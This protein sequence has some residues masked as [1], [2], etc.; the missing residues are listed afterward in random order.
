MDL[1]YKK[2]TIA[3][4]DLLVKTRI[5]VLRAA[6]GLADD[7]DM[8][9]VEHRS[10]AYYRKALQDNTHTAYLAFDGDRFAGAGG[11]SYYQVM[12]TFHNP[13]GNKAY[14]MNMYTRPEYRRQGIARLMLDILISDAKAR[15]IR[16]ITL[17]ATQAGRPLYI[18]AGFVPMEDE[19]ILAEQSC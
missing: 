8:T 16:F 18:N 10:Y 14:I 7:T 17:E 13:S 19:M 5:E 4:I 3:D 1:N 2:A 9:E 12:P 6:N 15:G 11:I